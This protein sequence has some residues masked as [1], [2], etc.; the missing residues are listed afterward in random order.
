MMRDPSYPSRR[1]FGIHA[2]ALSAASAAF[3]GFPMRAAW[4]VQAAERAPAF[5]LPGRDGNTVTLDALQGKVVL[6]DFWASWCAPCKLSMPWLSQMQAR[7]GA[8]GLQVV[9]VNLDRDAR[10]AEGFLRSL[11]A[12][13]GTPLTIAYD[14]AGETPRRYAVKA[15]PTT[16]LISADGTVA[17]HHAGFRDDDKPAL[18]AA[19]VAALARA[20]R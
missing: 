12:S 13:M 15:M 3:G 11:Q 7:H 2:L 1:L 16:V 20:T 17:L 8:R 14:A 9:A 6:L 5:S 10:A 4:A 18:E 19:I